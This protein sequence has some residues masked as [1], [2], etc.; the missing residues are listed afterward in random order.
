VREGHGLVGSG[1]FLIRMPFG[2]ERD[3][4][5]LSQRFKEL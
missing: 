2:L 4:D 5:H 1:L 3:L